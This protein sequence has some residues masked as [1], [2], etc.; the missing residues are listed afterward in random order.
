MNNRSDNIRI[1]RN[2]VF[3]YLK[4]IVTILAG[5]ITSRYVLKA[6][7][8]DD[9]GLYNVVG[10]VVALFSFITAS[11]A[12]TTQRFINVE[13]GKPDGNPGRMFNI[14]NVIHIYSAF[15]L[16]AII[17]VVGILY[18]QNWINVAPGKE[19]D[20]M[21]VFQISTIA[22]CLG[23]SNV[24][25]QSMLMAHE[26]FRDHA[27][28]EIIFT[29]IK[30]SLVLCLVF[31]KGNLL[32]IYAIFMSVSTILSF[33]TY[34]LYC[35]KQWKQTV[36]WHY[37]SG[38]RNYKEALSF[39]NYNLLAATGSVV[40]WQGSNVLLNFFFGTAVNA[41]YGIS[42]L[43]SGYVEKFT[44]NIAIAAAPQL[45]QS[46]GGNDEERTR[47]LTHTI[48]RLSLLVVLA[49]FFTINQEL[50][51]LLSLWL[52]A[53]VPPLAADF[54][55]YA[56]ILGVISTTTLGL[57]QM[58][59][60][61]GKIKWFK[62]Q[63]TAIYFAMLGLAIPLYRSGAPAHTIFILYIAGDALSRCLFL[64]LSRTIL[65]Y[66]VGTFMV[67]A[68][69]RPAIISAIMT[70]WFFLCRQIGFESPAAKLGNVAVTCVLVCLL[71]FIVGLKRKEKQ[72]IFEI[73]T[74]KTSG[75]LR[76]IRYRICPVKALKK[77]LEKE[78]RHYDLDDP[79]DLNEKI[80]WLVTHKA[81][82]G[83]GRYADKI[84]VRDYVTKMG[85]GDLVI[86]LLG[87]WKR[88]KD[89][90]FDALPQKFVLKCNHDSGSTVIIDKA[91]GYDKAAICAHLDKALKQK[92]GDTQGEL[93]YNEIPPRIL[94]EPVLECPND[95]TSIP[96]YKVWCL[97]GEPRFI[98]ACYDRS[99]DRV[100]VSMYDT[101]WNRHP[102]NCVFSDHFQDAGDRPRPQH[103]EEMLHA[104]TVL[105][106]GFPEIR[107]DFYE[108]GGR[109]YFGEMTMSSMGG[110]MDYLTDEFKA[111]MG[112]LCTIK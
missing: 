41:A 42:N 63:Y 48:A 23:I 50:E 94:A 29:L 5:I 24:P 46:F 16:F 74:R 20:A 55:R 18:I 78:G 71:C 10:S 89:I 43:V 47:Y 81:S 26:R 17:E 57:T 45:I 14:C 62:I 30:L 109:L 108:S 85:L 97:D 8:I 86:P 87:T 35:H 3:V 90:D 59:N 22:A 84:A 12:G 19:G 9:Y 96:D 72:R 31:C 73:F 100:L 53:N 99:A 13:L 2:T 75:T 33:V 60:A 38:W 7:G 93:F 34:R 11:L 37:V 104:A 61:T 68:Y 80:L 52:G 105:A 6:L 54:C 88:A 32:R 111:R 64:L 4:L 79:K 83:W 21:F 58:I 92:Y 27:F 95:A 112:A 51:Y 65:H 77:D 101:S 110:R 67:R 98:W 28:I 40:R 76:K 25:F 15:I 82:K 36:K 44:G 56:L 69:T 66:P 1:A 70:G 106:K 103:L 91:A 39:N 107:V 102:E 49:L